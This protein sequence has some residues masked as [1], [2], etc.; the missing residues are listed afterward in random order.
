MINI[1]FAASLALAAASGISW[2]LGKD[3]QT[4]IFSML[5]AI[6]LLNMTFL[7]KRILINFEN[8]RYPQYI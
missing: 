4:A 1:L 7:L 8:Q 6:Y 3:I 5:A 2:F